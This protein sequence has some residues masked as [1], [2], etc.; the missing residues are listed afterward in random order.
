MHEVLLE[1]EDTKKE[2]GM[3]QT[4]PWGLPCLVVE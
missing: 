2:I 1:L 4:S 3:K